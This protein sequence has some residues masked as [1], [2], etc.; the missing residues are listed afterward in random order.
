MNY[1]NISEMLKHRVEQFGEKPLYYWHDEQ[2][3][4]IDQCTYLNFY[5]KANAIATE[6]VERQ[7]AGKMV[8][9]V[10]TPG[11]DYIRAFMG[12]ILAGAIPIPMYPPFSKSMVQHMQIILKDAQPNIIL[13]NRD[14]FS[15]IRK[16]RVMRKLTNLPLARYFTQITNLDLT[17]GIPSFKGI[18]VIQIDSIPEKASAHLNVAQSKLA[19]IQYTSGSTG[20][21]K[22]VMIT[23]EN[24]LTNLLHIQKL[25]GISP[26]DS[27]VFWLPPYHDMGLIGGMLSNMN[28][29][30]TTYWTSPTTFIFKPFTWLKLIS[31]NHATISCAPNFAYDLCLKRINQEELETLDLRSWKT[32]MNGADFIR[33]ETLKNFANKFEPTGFKFSSF[34]PCY[35]LAEATLIVTGKKQKADPPETHH[36]QHSHM[37]DD[38]QNIYTQ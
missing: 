37:S 8:A 3:N 33:Y 19:F 2:L 34:Y 21:P 26:E 15:K 11:L 5:E 14:T 4:V 10:F 18:D 24:L 30:S 25:A 35:G 12:C 31:N 22:G 38:D 23:Q 36:Y 13:T 9:I 28:T 27:S 29:G 7:V 32:A 17:D 6:L 1:L 20:H 16:L